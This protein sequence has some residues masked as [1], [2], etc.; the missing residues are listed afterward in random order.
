VFQDFSLS[1]AKF[2]KE[3]ALLPLA[4]SLS[5]KM[6]NLG[7]QFFTALPAALGRLQ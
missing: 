4:S 7:F 5:P 3:R 1:L 6:Y 2:V